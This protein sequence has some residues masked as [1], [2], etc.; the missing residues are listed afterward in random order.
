MELNITYR[1]L[2]STEAMDTRIREKAEHLKKYFKG[3]MEIHWVCSVEG[4]MHLNEVNIHA[5]HHYFHASA[6]SDNM[7][8][9]LDKVLAKLE[10][11]IRRKD[12]KIKDKSKH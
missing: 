8:K 7:Y 11:Q 4:G 10:Q 1:H 2:D 9:T 3:K 6:E 5:G 12:K